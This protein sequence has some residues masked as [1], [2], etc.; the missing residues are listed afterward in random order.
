LATLDFPPAPSLYYSH[1]SG[2]QYSDSSGGE[3]RG[4]QSRYPDV[5]PQRLDI[6]A[7]Y[8]DGGFSVGGRERER[9]VTLASEEA[10]FE[11]WETERGGRA[12]ETG[13]RETERGGRATE[14][15]ARETEQVE[16]AVSPQKGSNSH[17]Q[18]SVYGKSNFTEHM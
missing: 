4:E 5:Y 17:S 18:K 3:G 11:S 13:G 1:S 16:E 6:S 2:S 7:Q 14:R 9:K 15:G 8:L 12:T 10:S